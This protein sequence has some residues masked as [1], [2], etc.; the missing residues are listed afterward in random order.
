MISLVGPTK[1]TNR[2]SDFKAEIKKAKGQMVTPSLL[3]YP[4]RNLSWARGQSCTS[5]EESNLVDG[6]LY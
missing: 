1:H 3:L 2:L 4:V 6:C 5:L